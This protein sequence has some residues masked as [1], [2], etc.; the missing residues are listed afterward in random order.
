MP[1]LKQ[2][3]NN[4]KETKVVKKGERAHRWKGMDENCPLMQ[5]MEKEVRIFEDKTTTLRMKIAKKYKIEYHSLY[6]TR[7]VPG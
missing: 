7:V 5:E 6:F 1:K 3:P 2:Q 4:K